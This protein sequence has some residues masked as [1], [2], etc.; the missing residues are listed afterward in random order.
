M[1]WIDVCYENLSSFPQS[2]SVIVDLP[3]SVPTS[4]LYNNDLINVNAHYIYAL[5]TTFQ[6]IRGLTK[7]YLLRLP[8][9]IS[10]C[11]NV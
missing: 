5:N 7:I 11:R 3:F 1:C 10:M 8:G 4:G 6:E 2:L 9:I